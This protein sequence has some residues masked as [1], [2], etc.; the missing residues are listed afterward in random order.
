MIDQAISKSKKLYLLVNQQRLFN[1]TDKMP[2]ISSSSA[3]FKTE[4]LNNLFNQKLFRQITIQDFLG[5]AIEKKAG[6]KE[7]AEIA[8]MLARCLLDFFEDDIKLA[9][10]S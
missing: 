2:K 6:F 1:I 7:K 3:S 5:K 10:Y 8:L 9:S 4:A